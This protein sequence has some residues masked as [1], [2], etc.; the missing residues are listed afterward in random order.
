[1]ILRRR[2]EKNR[3]TFSVLCRHFFIRF[4]QND[5]ITFAEQQMEKIVIFIVILSVA[6]ALFSYS[7]LFPKY[8]WTPDSPATWEEKCYFISIFMLVFAVLSILEW[9]N[10]FLDR[11]DFHNLGHL[12]VSMGRILLA[13]IAAMG[14]FVALYCLGAALLS[15]IIFAGMLTHL[16]NSLLY[17]ARYFFAHFV[18]IWAACFFVFFMCAL[19]QSFFMILLPRAWFKKA[20]VYLQFLWIVASLLLFSGIGWS[21]RIFSGWLK[22]ADI[23]VFAFPSLWFTGMY[24]WIIGRSDPLYY[25]LTMVGTGCLV[26]LLFVYTGMA[27]IGYRRHFRCENEQNKVIAPGGKFMAVLKRLLLRHPHERAVYDFTASTLKRSPLHRFRMG[28]FLAVGTALALL[29]FIEG[30]TFGSG[31]LALAFTIAP[32]HLLFILALV[33]LWVVMEI[34]M[35]LDAHWIFRISAN[36]KPA[37]YRSAVIKVAVIRVL[38][39]LAMIGAIFHWLNDGGNFAV[40]HTVFVFALSLVV[41]ETLFLQFHKI[42][43]ACSYLPGKANLKTLAGPYLLA[44]LL[45]LTLVNLIEQFCLS[46]PVAMIITIFLLLAAAGILHWVG[47]RRKGED[48]Q[49][50]E[51]PDP[52]MLSLEIDHDDRKSLCD[53]SLK[54]QGGNV[55]SLIRR[56]FPLWIVVL[57]FMA[58]CTGPR[59][60]PQLDAE[61][62]LFSQLRQ[63]GDTEFAKMHWRG[64]KN[65]VG[66]YEEALDKRDEPELRQR[67]FTAYIL[68]SLRETELFFRDESWLQKAEALLPRVPAAP[69]TAY[70]AIAQ[71][72]FY[73]HA[74]NPGGFV[75]KTLELEKYPLLRE[76]ESPLSYYM[77]LQF[78]RLIT[79]RDTTEKFIGEEKEF[80][81]LH[82]NSNLA[83]YLRSNTPQEM[84][85]KLEAFPDFA[86]MVMLRGNWHNTGKKYQAALA[87]YQR[88]VE[89][90]PVL[91]KARNAM[92]TL[93]YSLQEYEQALLHYR[94]TL[95]IYPLEPTAL[96]GRAICLSE[97]RRYDESDRALREM[98]EK[99]TFYHGEANYYLAKNCYYRNR[100]EE[101]RS[102]LKLAAAYIPDSPEMNMLSGLLYLD[103][104]Q[105]GRAA[106]D[107][108][109]ALEQ[110]PQHAEAWYFLGQAARQEKKFREARSH[111]QS[112]IENFHR[113]L[114]E[115]DAKLAAM[116]REENSDPYRRSYFLKRQ[117]QRNEYAREAI[118]RLAS[119]QKTFRKPPLPGLG[120]LLA[121]LTAPPPRQ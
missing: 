83:V 92:A 100:P 13:K 69:C 34:P 60:E 39:P 36:K 15:G 23:R 94:Q 48:L 42:P 81:N 72:K 46:R 115:F 82:G 89:I 97:L 44:L 79:T 68:L 43:F 96:F 57:C 54:G 102:Y 55:N 109:K 112:A 70:L 18:S 8:L 37:V 31:T 106:L 104:G 24:Q 99:Q 90:M 61:A 93:C 6:G 119:L 105:P 95:E 4:F 41:M 32:L 3:G 98:I 84:A 110:Q 21:L 73:V 40:I 49:F 85:E 80:I 16:Q 29:L 20:G 26:L 38:M 117:R 14:M 74:L 28:G 88:A 75:H 17:G 30:I 76:T 1:M 19:I 114:G 118:E 67:L 9:D 66:F 62:E 77:Y 7:I 22:N 65:S 64:W 45:Y 113:E 53:P 5:S 27:L 10:L 71:K 35:E 120:E 33:G 52:V 86:E 63:Q 12:P 121:K 108:R 11:R 50:F 58:S 103:R 51:E 107:F 47:Q 59:T 2:K 116:N 101:T 111:F 56:F 78:L 91:Y 87:D 25:R